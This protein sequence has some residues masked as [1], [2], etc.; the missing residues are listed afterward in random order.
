MIVLN[1][2]FLEGDP[3]QTT[4][5]QKRYGKG[6]YFFDK[7]T[8]EAFEWFDSR[9]EKFKPDKPYEGPLALRSTWYFG[10]QAKKKWGTW[11]TTKSDCD[12]LNKIFQDR[13]GKLGF[14]G[15]DAQISSLAIEKRYADANEVTGI[16]VEICSLSEKDKT[17]F[18][19][20]DNSCNLTS[21]L[22]V[23][24][25]HSGRIHRIGDEQHDSLIVMHKFDES[26]HITDEYEIH[27]SNMQNG[28]GGTCNDD[29]GHGYQIL[30]TESGFFDTPV[31]PI[32]IEYRKE[33]L[34]YLKDQGEDP[35]GG[36]WESMEK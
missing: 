9:L 21:R 30:S 25:K 5:Q 17:A 16:F 2:F 3:P 11:K 31:C 22:F 18:D 23:L 12:N 32:Q 36:Y 34:Q 28:D 10:I 7:R 6:H 13:M 1:R 4:S 15:D 14:W 20:Y 35:Y 19:G 33:I 24:D 29:E 8:E 27:Y 26:G